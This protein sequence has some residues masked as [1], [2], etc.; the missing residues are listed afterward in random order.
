MS[1]FSRQTL[2]QRN[3]ALTSGGLATYFMVGYG[4]LNLFGLWVAR[5][6]SFDRPIFNLD[7]LAAGLVYVWL[8]RSVAALLMAALFV[9]EF[10]RYLLP[11]YFFSTQAFSVQFWLRAASNWSPSVQFAMALATAAFV[12]PLVLFFRRYRLSR[13]NKIEATAWILGTGVLLMAA[14]AL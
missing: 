12:V 10:I 1:R 13:R 14:D 2:F 11:T 9:T 3:V 5:E 7:Y 4:A 8:S 6:W